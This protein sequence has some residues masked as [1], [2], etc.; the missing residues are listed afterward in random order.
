MPATAPSEGVRSYRT[1]K[2]NTTIIA[3]ARQMN[4]VNDDFDRSGIDMLLPKR[5]IPIRSVP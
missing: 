4:W 3:I 2:L 1:W 5:V